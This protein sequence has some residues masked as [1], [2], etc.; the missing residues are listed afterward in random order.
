[1]YKWYAETIF[2][3]KLETEQNIVF[4]N[5]VLTVYVQQ[6]VTSCEWTKV[7][8]CICYVG[9]GVGPCPEWET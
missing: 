9:I 7:E 6:I 8:N 4:Q 3:V 2:L 5:Y 1:M